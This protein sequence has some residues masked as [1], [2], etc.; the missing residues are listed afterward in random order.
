LNN[1]TLITSYLKSKGHKEIWKLLYLI[2]WKYILV[3]NQ[4]LFEGVWE[5]TLS[6]AVINKIDLRLI[7]NRNVELTEEILNFVNFVLEKKER[8]SYTD[9]ANMYYSTYPLI[10]TRK[11]DLINLFECRKE[12]IKTLSEEQKSSILSLNSFLE[13]K[14]DKKLDKKYFLIFI[15]F[16]IL[17]IGIYIYV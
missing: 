6:G 8:L 1:L 2:E 14:K 7:E 10:N 17:L 13:K 11:G 15:F 4:R 9:F 12:Y 3:H 16:I 5:Y